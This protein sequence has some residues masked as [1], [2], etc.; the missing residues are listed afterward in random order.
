MQLTQLLLLGSLA[1][2]ISVLAHST[3]WS[4]LALWSAK[5]RAVPSAEPPLS[6]AIL[7]MIAGIALA[8]VFW[9]SWGLAAITESR[10]WVRGLYFGGLSWFALTLPTIASLVVGRMIDVR[11][12][13]FVAS[14]WATTAIAVGLACS[15]SWH[16]G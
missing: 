16:L 7:H 12:S 5:T 10:W 4:A 11:A 9:L 14:R 8:F 1:G 13:M 3:L 15:W 2:L 6:E